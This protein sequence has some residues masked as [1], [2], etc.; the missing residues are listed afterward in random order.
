MASVEHEVKL[1]APADFRLPDLN[2]VVDGMTAARVSDQELK[3]T[4]YDTPDLRLARWGVSLRYRTGEGE[5]RWTLK[6]PAEEGGSGIRRSELEFFESP[7][8]I[9]PAVSALV[10]A[11]VR[12]SALG[13]V[14][15]LRTTRHLVE[16]RDELDVVR[17][18]VCDDDVS[19]TQDAAVTPA[20][21]ELEVEAAAGGDH[22]LKP[23]AKR[24]R[25]AGAHGG[26]Q[27][28]KVAR[29]LGPAVEIPEVMA[30]TLDDDDATAGDVVRAAI[31]RSVANL[32]RH[33][34]G[35]RLGVDP[36]DIHQARVATRRLRSD[37][38]TFRSLVDETWAADLREQLKWLA[39]LFG[40]VR[41]RD[42][43][44]ERLRA[45]VAALPA[46]D[47]DGGLALLDALEQERTD[48]R[49]A[50]LVAMDEPRYVELVEALVTAASAPVLT[51]EAA[52]PARP[53]LAALVR[54]QVKHVDGAVAALASPPADEELHEV[55]IRSKRARYAADA[56]TPV[57]GK[58]ARRLAR[59]MAHVQTV[60]GDL[61]DAVVTEEWLR[62][63]AQVSVAASFAAGEL[64]AVQRTAMASS[65]AAFPA[66]WKQA[67]AP[68][69]RSWLR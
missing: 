64:V 56:A 44:R 52:Q 29:V 36:E 67:S 33:D 42:V 4:Y 14:A 38:R 8:E 62:R 57:W 16:L 50:L 51:D 55:R 1:D 24:L 12:S 35:V 10:R 19:V 48:A 47:H 54:K 46:D 43:L 11:F 45:A 37:L 31:A 40:E 59:A 66:A 5:P 65:R 30:V 25:R 28:S 23:V 21:R 3:A 60:L 22:L 9:P 18:V 27:Q 2:G 32:L 39:G 13:E 68:K 17:A 53:V 49:A 58:R 15:E 41:D 61:Q 26:R 6:L 7:A 20:F 69:L 63:G 34:P